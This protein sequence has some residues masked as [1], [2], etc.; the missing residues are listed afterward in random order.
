MKSKTISLILFLLFLF[1]LSIPL[2]FKFAPYGFIL[3]TFFKVKAS[4]I[5]INI[6]LPKVIVPISFVLSH[7]S[8]MAAVGFFFLKKPLRVSEN[9]LSIGRNS[10]VFST[11]TGEVLGSNKHSETHV[12]A[13]GGGGYINSQGGGYVAPPQITSTTIN[14]HEFWLRLPNGK[15]Q[16]VTLKNVQIPLRTGQ[17]VSLISGFLN[18]ADYGKYLKLIN[19]NELKAWN[20][21]SDESIVDEYKLAGNY[22]FLGFLAY[23]F[24]AIFTFFIVYALK[25]YGFLGRK[26]ASVVVSSIIIFVVLLFSSLPAASLEE[27]RYKPFFKTMLDELT[28]KTVL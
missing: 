20:I 18:K 3:K 1:F 21:L 15:E 23:L 28:K 24:G 22:K 4:S 12:H 9:Q 6:D 11:T 17:K 19:H 5:N 16:S 7:L 26:T 8:L 2:A 14:T 25:E 10:I 13:S 27:R